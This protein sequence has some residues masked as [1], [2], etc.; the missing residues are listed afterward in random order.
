MYWQ[1]CDWRRNRMEDGALC[2]YETNFIKL[3]FVFFTVNV[4][5][6]VK[7]E[8]FTM[9]VRFARLERWGER[10]CVR[11]TS[12][13]RPVLGLREAS[14][15]LITQQLLVYTRRRTV[16][17]RLWATAWQH[18]KYT[19]HSY[20]VGERLWATAWQHV[21]YTVHSYTV[22]ERLW[23]TAW[24]HVKYTVHS[25]TVGER[26][27]ATAWQHVKDTV[28]SYTVGERLW[29]TAWQTRRQVT[30]TSEDYSMSCYLTV[31]VWSK[32]N[33]RPPRLLN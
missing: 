7:F 18:V 3:N 13:L 24:Q 26:L 27:W 25:Y 32:I 31:E 1:Y 2:K 9:S 19:V 14:V 30:V 33:V 5:R 10:V 17:E 23:A 21:K 4:F 12:A 15:T 11:R 22:G 8:Y 16:G 29:A 6:I 20:T 28:H